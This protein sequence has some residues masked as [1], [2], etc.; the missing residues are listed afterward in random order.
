[1]VELEDNENFDVDAATAKA[2]EILS[3]N[4]KGFFLMVEWDLHPTQAGS[5]AWTRQSSS[6]GWCR[7]RRSR[8]A[9]NTLV[10]FTADHSFD[11]RVLSGKKGED[12]RLPAAPNVAKNGTLTEEKPAVAVGTSHTGEEVLIAAQGP[13]SEKVV[14]IHVE[15]RFVPR[16]DVGLR[17]AG[18]PAVTAS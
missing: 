2:I 10:L 15:Y 14:G 9:A 12:L 5:A 3:H 8:W 6:T 7:R 18:G 17:V 4:P 16:D 13:G 11:F 1:M